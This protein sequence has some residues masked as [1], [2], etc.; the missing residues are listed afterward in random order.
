MPAR[1]A[2]VEPPYSPGVEAALKKWMPPGVA[3]EPLKLFRVLV[4][5]EV[6]SERMRGLGAAL[7]G[8]SR[9]PIRFRELLILRTCARCRAEYEWG[10]HAA[11]FAAA[12]GLDEATVRATAGAPSG[13]PD[14]PDGDDALAIR[15]AD[16]LHDRATL[17]DPRWSRLSARFGESEVLEVIAVAGFY[18]L[19]SFMV[20]AAGVELE[21][22]A[23][24][25]PDSP[26]RGVR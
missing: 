12:A 9:L 20:N 15:V 2:P 4:R 21:P 18:H 8:R 7:L 25:F 22:W 16:E 14:L 1:I 13:A 17:S 24:R 3:V 26:A 23:A 6:L 5:H 11:A 19:I 10:V